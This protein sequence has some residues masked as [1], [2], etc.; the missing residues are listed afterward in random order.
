MAIFSAFAILLGARAVI[1]QFTDRAFLQNHGD[2]RMLRTVSIPAHRGMITDR[3]GEP[4]AISTPVSSVWA[5]PRKL[6]LSNQQWRQLAGMLDTDVVSLKALVDARKGKDFVYLKRQVDPDDAA[7]VAAADL[8]GISIDGEY[9]RYYPASE[10]AAHLLGFTNVDD[11]GQEG[12][13]LEYNAVLNGEP[14]AMR[15]IKDRLG[16]T[17]ENVESIRPPKP[18]RDLAL[19]IDKRLQ[20]IAYRELKAGVLAHHA[21]AGTMVILD[22]KTGEV[23]AMVTQPSYNPNNRADLRGEYYRNRAVTDVFEPGSAL[24]PFTIAAALGTGAYTPDT[25]IETAPGYFNVGPFKVRDVHDYGTLDVTGVITKSSNVGAAKIALSLEPKT[26][27]TML[28]N[29]GF[30]MV[31]DSGFPGEA[32]GRLSDYH[33][34]REIDQATIAFGYGIS[35]TALQLAKAFT[36]IAN[37]GVLMPVSLLRV[38]HPVQGKRVMS[39]KIAKEVLAMMETVVERGTGRKAYIPGYRVAGKT[40]TVHKPS[41]Q[42]YSENH[43]QAIFAGIVPASHPRLI[44]VVMVDDPAGAAYFG[45]LV[46][47]PIF[48]K[49]MQEALRLMNVPP[50]DP[51]S[52][53][54]QVYA[55]IPADTPDAFDD[56]GKRPSR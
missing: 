29:V 18:G 52:K 30:G 31:T 2:A 43:Y 53:G 50:D 20:Y 14:G 54:E 49:V 47:A 44:A 28:N 15:V 39:K 36:A 41:P 45:G 24:K 12:I 5:N 55:Y 32:M 16:R 8:P 56:M 25:R 38:D 48:S 34:W 6:S 26:I 1:L 4:L 10:V 23:L 21:Q 37:D 22:A 27:W 7:R 51:P 13:E 33:N 35:V 19:S 46:A 3:F 17:V 11:Q 40:G 42:G 9:R